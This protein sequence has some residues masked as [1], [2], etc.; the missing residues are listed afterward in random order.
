MEPVKTNAARRPAAGGGPP[1]G[2]HM[3][4]AGGVHRALE[5]A[6]RYRCDTVQLF[7]KNQRQWRA[8]PLRCDD[9]ERWFALLAAPGFG[10]P[11]AHA[12]YL[13]NLASP[14]RTLLARSRR[15]FAEE[16]RRCQ[17]LQIPYLVVHPGSATGSSPARA[18]ARVARSL[19]YVFDRH[20]GL[21]VMPLLETT[22]GQGTVLGRT[23]AELG[24]IIAQVQEPGRIG[25]CIDTCHVFAAGY[26]LRTV[27]GYH[28]MVA[29]ANRAFG[30]DRVRCWHLNDSRHGLGSRRDRH[31]HIGAGCLGLAGFRHV[32]GD[33]RFARIPMIIETPKGRDERGRDWDAVNLARLRRI[34]ARAR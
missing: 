2:A 27:R 33:A 9:V 17:T 24:E 10:P 32:L 20:P 18:L 6:R 16:L 34:A 25:V 31:T 26:D 21:S 4:I 28:D 15:A 30:L 19:D 7:V 1:I 29:C 3:S 13:I 5:A 14:D 23:F 12:T 11:V 8:A 22:A